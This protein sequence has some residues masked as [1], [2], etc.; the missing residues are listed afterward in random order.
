MANTSTPVETKPKIPKFYE[1]D[2]WTKSIGKMSLRQRLQYR[3]DD[4]TRKLPNLSLVEKREIWRNEP[5]YEISK[6]ITQSAGWE[7]PKD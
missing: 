5:Y 7:F 3:I 6:L 2:H 1:S 4:I